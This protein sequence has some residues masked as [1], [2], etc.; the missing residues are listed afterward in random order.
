MPSNERRFVRSSE[1]KIMPTTRRVTVS[2]SVRTVSW[3]AKS[4]S[5]V[6][7]A[8][9]G[10]ALRHRDLW[11]ASHDNTMTCGALGEV[12]LQRGRG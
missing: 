6:V 5:N 2:V 1:M 4:F 7:V 9:L 10:V 3:R 12:V 8:V 11:S